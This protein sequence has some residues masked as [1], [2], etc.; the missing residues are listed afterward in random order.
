MT[1]RELNQLRNLRRE[2]QLLNQL[3]AKYDAALY[4]EAARRRKKAQI[5]QEEV[6]R[7]I[8]TAKRRAEEKRTQCIAEAERLEAWIDAADSSLVRMAMRLRFI[9]GLSWTAV[10]FRIGGGN[11]EN[12]VKKMVY[13]YIR[14]SSE[15][16]G[17]SCPDA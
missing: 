9:D 1:L 17:E 10:A 6:T 8:E 7:R 14:R 11:T 16:C 12:S 13:R 15:G 5:P 4:P 2:I 3:T